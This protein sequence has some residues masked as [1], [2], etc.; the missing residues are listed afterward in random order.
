[1]AEV[2]ATAASAVGFIGLAG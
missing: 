2:L 1:M